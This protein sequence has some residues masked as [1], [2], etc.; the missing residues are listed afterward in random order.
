[1]Q[2]IGIT[3][4]LAAG[5]GTVVEYLQTKDFK[6]YSVRA[7]LT[8]ILEEKGIEINRK[9]MT[10]L[11]NHL[12]TEHG[13]AYVIDQLYEKAKEYGG[14][15]VI[16]SV[17]TLGEIDSLR[18]KGSFLLLA[19]DAPIE[20]RYDRIIARKS[21]TDHVSF[22]QFMADELRE[23]QST[24]PTKGNLPGCIKK[25]DLLIINNGSIE[26]LHIQLEEKIFSTK[27]NQQ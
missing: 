1:M 27:E 24:D 16:E 8:E 4:T 20:T 2:I 22:E 23:S 13:P 21:A 19:V 11:A 18:E 14:K 9:T 26:E 5:K 3:G 6:H 12:R 10:D 15:C 25:A 7:Y 17:R